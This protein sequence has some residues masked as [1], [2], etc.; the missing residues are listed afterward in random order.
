MADVSGLRFIGFGLGLI[1][2]AV[3]FIA[4][5]VVAENTRTTAPL[6]ASASSAV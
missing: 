4:A 6:A 5:I 3:L 1:T 2:A